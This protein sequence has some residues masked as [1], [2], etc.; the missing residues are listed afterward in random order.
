MSFIYFSANEALAL[1]SA[2]QTG[3]TLAEAEL[4][5]VQQQVFKFK[6]RHRYQVPTREAIGVMKRENRV[7]LGPCLI[8]HQP[9]MNL[10]MWPPE[11]GGWDLREQQ[12]VKGWGEQSKR[13][14]FWPQYT[15]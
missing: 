9:N 8:K 12:E 13:Q 4:G 11:T 14:I 5:P 15:E 7:S 3:H 1:E 10:E 6:V 2:Q